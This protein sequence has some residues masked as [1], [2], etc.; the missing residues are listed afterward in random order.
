MIA[1]FWLLACQPNQMMDPL[2]QADVAVEVHL[3]A[4]QVA[5]SEAVLVEVVLSSKAGWVA[6]PVD[7]VVDKLDVERLTAE[8]VETDS[9]EREIH[10][11]SLTGPSGNYVLEP[12]E[13]EFL[14]SDGESRKRE[15]ARLFF[16][17]GPE[18]PRSDLEGLAEL[19]PLKENPWR[20][21][22]LW[23]GLGFLLA[24]ILLFWWWKRPRKPIPVLP[25][26]APDKEALAAWAMAWND[27]DLDDH[28]RALLLSQIFRRYVERVFHL[29]ASAF[30]SMEVLE[31][32]S[33][34]LS[35]HHL[36]QSRRLLGATDR[37]K[38]ARRGGGRSLFESLNTD[39]RELIE[40][41]KPVP[42]E[43]VRDD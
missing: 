37:I 38:Y 11:F 30:T 15:S 31:Q 43:E 13:I 1:L 7:L 33:S 17:V 40:A 19:P 34:D 21:R 26:I 23:A 42:S 28:G 5:E 32:L 9:G 14:R 25:P 29:P 3:G 35:E 22:L 4:K 6:G 12:V 16:D 39:F 8:V 10:R 27:P 2:A 24:A 18:G 20:R 36:G 41:T